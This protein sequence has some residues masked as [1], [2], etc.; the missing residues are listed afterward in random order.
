VSWADFKTNVNTLVTTGWTSYIAISLSLIVLWAVVGLSAEYII[1]VRAEQITDKHKIAEKQQFQCAVAGNQD[2]AN[3]IQQ[4]R[5]QIRVLG[6][7][8]RES[9]IKFYS[10]FYT[11]YLVFTIFGI[12]AAIA[13]ALI[14]KR[15]MN[16]ASPHVIT[17]FMV[18]TAIAILYQGG[19]DVF[20]QKANIDNNS[21]LAI[22]H[23]VLADQIDTYCVTGKVNVVDPNAAFASALAK[24]APPT[25]NSNSSSANTTAPAKPTPSPVGI[26]P[27]YVEPNGDQ[28][29]NYVAW[30][31]EH[32]RNFSIA[33]DT[34]KVTAVDGKRFL[35]Q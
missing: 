16:D 19:F 11:S 8:H 30:Q 6:D 3:Y 14:V 18:C 29:I 24:S 13:L 22:D 20:Q 21:K 7:S 32:L 5:E 33:V 17:V 34:T 4:Q 28:F 12:I 15:G 26:Q 9:A 27:Y 35:L 31:M 1:R 2:K 25:G 23:A 10:Y